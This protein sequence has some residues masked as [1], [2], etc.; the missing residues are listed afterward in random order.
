MERCDDMPQNTI[1]HLMAI[2]HMIQQMVR[3]LAI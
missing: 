3:R 1:K 2:S